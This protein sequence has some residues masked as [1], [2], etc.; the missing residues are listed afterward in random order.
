MS[1]LL[2]DASEREESQ[3]KRQNRQTRGC[4]RV[5]PEIAASKTGVSRPYSILPYLPARVRL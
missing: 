5:A 4:M 3:S 2:G 1:A